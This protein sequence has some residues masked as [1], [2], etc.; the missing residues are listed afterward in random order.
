MRANQLAP[1]RIP[2][3]IKM[4]VLCVTL[5]GCT[6]EYSGGIR[7]S[8]DVEREERAVSGVRGVSVE[9]QGDLFIEIGDEEKLVIEAEDNLLEH[10]ETRVR[11]G[12]LRI[13]TRD[14]FGGL[15][16]RQPIR[17]YLTIPSADALESLEAGSAG[18]I[19]APRLEAGSFSIE[20]GSAGDVKIAELWADFLEVTISSAGDVTIGGGEVDEQEVTISSAGDYRA[21]DLISRRADVRLSS[22]GDARIQVDEY[23]D[24]RL[25]SSGD[26]IV[27]GDPEVRSRTSSSGDVIVRR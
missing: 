20:V 23:V 6:F 15:D 14:S 4:V 27:Y 16:N 18:D 1:R 9:N 26:L 12:I 3:R 22:A 13:G 21:E 19:E 25:T 8:G 7:G 2:Q 24:A 5:A 17:Y 10:I 11:G